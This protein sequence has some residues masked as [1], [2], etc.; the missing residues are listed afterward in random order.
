MKAN[1][2]RAPYVLVTAAYNEEGYIENAIK[3]IVAQ[4]HKPLC[5]LI[6]SDGS[7]DRTDEIVRYYGKCYSFIQLHHIS[8]DHPRNF[9]AQVHAINT[10]IARL[11]AYDFDFIGNLDA[12]ITLEPHILCQSAGAI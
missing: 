9:V 3:A 7:T 11:M 1:E 4:T 8:E 5:W 10:G 6:V 12:D 2:N